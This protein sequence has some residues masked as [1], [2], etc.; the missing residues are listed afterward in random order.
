MEFLNQN[1][2]NQRS[3]EI[4]VNILYGIY[5]V[6]LCFAIVNKGGNVWMAGFMLMAFFA[7]FSALIS[8]YRNV[9]VRA[10]ITCIMIQIMFIL[11]AVS[12][13][14]LSVIVP[15]FMVLL[16]LVAL[17]G[18]TEFL[19]ITWASLLFIVFYH[20]I[21]TDN[22]KQL[23]PETLNYLRYQLG[24]VLCMEVV[25]YVWLKHRNETSSQM[26]KIVEALMEAEQSKDDF[27]A[28]IS[29]EI[30][31][32]VNTICGMSEMAL[33]E[34]EL[35]KMR[36]EIFD[37]RDAGH[38]L[39]SLVSDI[40][41]FSQL[42]QGK[43]NLEEEAYNITSTINDIINMAMARRGDKQI[44]LIVDCA[45]DIPN[46]LFGDE[47]KI[48]RVIMNL[49]DN[50]IKFTSEGGVIIQIKVRRENYGVNLC[51]SVKDTGIGIEA[52]NL[53]KLFE[54]FTQVDTR[55]NRQSGGVGL[56]LA[57]SKE[58]IHHM[59]GPITV[60]GGLGK[61]STFCFVVPRK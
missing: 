19:W 23:S 59:G 16:L 55:R 5:T 51:I 25:L 11:Y 39:M 43:M 27:L 8:K 53:E 12:V 54:S 35:E 58:L 4:F 3:T 45:A 15:T 28:N 17:Y 7:S 18:R 37:I 10:A 24:N 29:H 52:A 36:E 57:I 40:L 2:K 21:I 1:K 46:V 41:D 32:P 9:R 33:H 60:R 48:R 44:E 26:Y 31:T 50:A 30:R 20:G 61:G 13:D 56:G 6:N 47:K 22:L 34:H 49:V 14:N 42:Q 38:N